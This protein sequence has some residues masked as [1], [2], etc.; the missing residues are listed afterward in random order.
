MAPKTTTLP[1]KNQK[2][3]T[4]CFPSTL[5]QNTGTSSSQGVPCT[6]SQSSETGVPD[7]LDP[8]T[9]LVNATQTST[10]DSQEIILAPDSQISD[11]DTAIDSA[12]ESQSS[13][14]VSKTPS[15]KRARPVST[16][17]PA[18]M[19]PS[20]AM[21]D[22]DLDLDNCPAS[23]TP[24]TGME[25][26]MDERDGGDHQATEIAVLSSI[27]GIDEAKAE[28]LNDF[29][30]L[31]NS[32]VKKDIT[33][34]LKKEIK[35][36]DAL[37]KQQERRIAELEALLESC[38][39]PSDHDIVSGPPPPPK[40]SAQQ[41]QPCGL[42][43]GRGGGVARR[44]R[45]KSAAGGTYAAA[46]AKSVEGVAGDRKVMERENART[47]SKPVQQQH[48]RQQPQP[49]KRLNFEQKSRA[50]KLDCIANAQTATGEEFLAHLKRVQEAQANPTSE[51]TTW[52]SVSYKNIFI[53]NPLGNSTDLVPDPFFKIRSILFD[54]Y[55]VPRTVREILFVGIKKSVLEI[56]VKDSDLEEAI[57][58]LSNPGS[59]LPTLFITTNL[60]DTPQHRRLEHANPA[61]AEQSVILH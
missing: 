8:D 30:N 40:P 23:P 35:K 52:A 1:A 31:K 26:L 28:K 18:Q 2:A 16:P 51:P 14:M 46:A 25:S 3:I 43:K 13:T 29:F 12:I 44:S 38:V 49:T 34:S 42:T 21:A 20:V 37:I 19:P 36:K 4:S 27:L 22:M 9:V 39:A 10:L 45:S 7:S 6:Q 47:V 60:L 48:Q 15:R 24:A 33:D 53:E 56:F 61:R 50:K 59:G 54:I 11:F 17:S 58:A 41:M 32:K 55:K 57:T 5:T